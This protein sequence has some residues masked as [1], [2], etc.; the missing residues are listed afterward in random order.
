MMN[1]G[2]FFNRVKQI[3]RYDGLISLNLQ[4]FL[5]FQGI[6]CYRLRGD[7]LGCELDY[8]GGF[9]CDFNGTGLETFF[10]TGRLKQGAIA[11]KH[12]YF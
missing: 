6:L 9:N 1:N 5:T 12:Q 11:F 7:R 8:Y 3:S 2:L 10:Y 4:V